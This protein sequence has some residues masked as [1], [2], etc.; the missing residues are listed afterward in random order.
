MFDANLEVFDA[1]LEVFVAGFVCLQHT[2]GPWIMSEINEH[3]DRD[4][5]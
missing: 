5:V 4:F 1:N 3:I 2:R